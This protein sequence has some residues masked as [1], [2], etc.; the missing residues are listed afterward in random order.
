MGWDLPAELIDLGLGG[1]CVVVGDALPLGTT[2]RLQVNAPQLWEPLLVPARVAW[3][4]MGKD[5]RARLGLRFEA[6]SP[7]T[8]VVL[9]EL[10][11]PSG[12]F[13]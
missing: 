10:I 6:D 5:G 9:A 8:L 4:R 1:A 12:S 7:S 3:T 2:V 11:G 13:V